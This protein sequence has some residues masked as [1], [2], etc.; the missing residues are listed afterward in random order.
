[1]SAPLPQPAG[2]SGLAAVQ[3]PAVD[4]DLVAFFLRQ[5]RPLRRYLRAQGCADSDCDDIVQDA[6]LIVRRRWPIIAYYDDPKAYLYKVAIRLWHRHAA[7]TRRGG[8][9]DDHEA[10]LTGMAD[11]ADP[12]AGVELSDRLTRWFR[13]LPDRQREVAALRLIADLSEV[14]TAQILG[15]SVGTVKS[16]LNAARTTLKQLKEREE[17]IERQQAGKEGVA[18]ER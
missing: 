4:E 9:R 3:A 12:L 6:F 16:Q 2:P 5:R 13:H 11:P 15:V 1:M 17:H 14:Q 18:D 8:Y 7:R 10:Y